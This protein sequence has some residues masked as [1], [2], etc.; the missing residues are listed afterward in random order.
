MSRR[1]RIEFVERL[2]NRRPEAASYYASLLAQEDPANSSIRE[3]VARESVLSDVRSA[4]DAAL[5]TIVRRERPVF[6]VVAADEPGGT[7]IDEEDAALLGPDAEGLKDSLVGAKDRIVPLFSRIGRIDLDGLAGMPFV[8]TGWLID[9]GIVVTNRHVAEVFAARDGARFKFRMGAYGRPLTA[10]FDTGHLRGQ[11]EG[12]EAPAIAEVLYVEPASS[13]VDIAFFRLAMSPRSGTWS[14]LPI[15]AERLSADAELCAIGYPAR[16]PRSVIPDQDLMRELYRGVYDVKRVAPGRLLRE[17]SDLMTHDCTTLGGNSGCAVASLDTGK[18]VGLHFAGVYLAE[19]RAVPASVLADYAARRRWLLPA[20]VET[21][22]AAL[23]QPQATPSGLSVTVTVTVNGDATTVT[24]GATGPVPQAADV[25][26]AV[27][28]VLD[29][30]IEGVVAARIGYPEDGLEIGGTPFVAVS[31][32]PSRLSEARR[33]GPSVQWGHAVRYEAATLLEQIE[34]MGIEE[35]TG[36]IA[37]DDDARTA[38]NFKLEP[39]TEEIVVRAHV[40]PEYGFEE[41]TAFLSG[42]ETSL[43]SAMYEFKGVAIADVLEGALRS[44]T[45]MR[46]IVDNATLP[47]PKPSEKE[48]SVKDL[49]FR[50]APRFN[51]WHQDYDFEYTKVPQG[52][53]GLIKNSYHIKVT[54]R[55][56]D[57]FWLSSGN[58]KNTSSQ[59]IVSDI[60]RARALEDDLPG[61][62]DWHVVVGSQTLSTLL[63]SH[64]QQDIKRCEELRPVEEAPYRQLFVMVPQGEF[65]TVEERKPPS[66]L[67]K[68]LAIAG[69]IKVWPL[70][71]PDRDGRIY[72]DAVLS[73]IKSARRSLWFQI[74]YMGMRPDPRVHRGNIDELLD[75]LCEKMLELNDARVLLRTKNSRF[76]DNRHVAWYLKSKGVD[77]ATCLRA[78]DDHHT[79]GMIVDGKRVLLGSHNWSGDGVSLNRDASL[80]FED[81]RIAGY[82]GEAFDIDWQRASPIRPKR[83]EESV[84]E[85]VSSRPEGLEISGYE[86]RT[87]DEYLA[88]MEA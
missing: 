77:V 86:I 14:P 44:G 36:A 79:K 26:A 40:S 75:A 10:A 25:G 87:L 35:A 4:S 47:K 15:S 70:L 78:M 6:F 17:T 5:E 65:E 9:D 69:R 50:A 24:T 43:V 71:T 84:L 66:R 22:G 52:R 59:P 64:I 85:I 83:L 19:N 57:H 68:P 49:E 30:R 12:G 20:R 81:E 13:S 61:N 7:R 1:D 33:N 3:G 41:L 60:D 29:R 38:K 48:E 42:P 55:A 28:A 74:P 73:L 72:T 76:N 53:R 31:V 80:I 56:D 23:P 46:L 21:A 58:W 11:D 8:G 34:E 45:S 16:A 27:A 88:E 62:R 63:R 39:V 82:Y 32:K 51:E 67:L 18:I 37:Y 2:L 54:V